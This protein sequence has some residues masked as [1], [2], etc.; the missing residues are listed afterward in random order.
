VAHQCRVFLQ[1]TSQP[2][3]F[4]ELNGLNYVIPTNQFTN[5]SSAAGTNHE[6]GN[7]YACRQ[8]QSDAD[9]NQEELQKLILMNEKQFEFIFL[10]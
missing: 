3:K 4:Y 6:G 8:C 5:D 7:E 10:H 9:G 2:S 1:G